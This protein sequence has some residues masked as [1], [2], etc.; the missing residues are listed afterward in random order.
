MASQVQALLGL[1]PQDIQTGRDQAKL[2]P[3][4]GEGVGSDTEGCL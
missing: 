3:G 1:N 4:W 2:V